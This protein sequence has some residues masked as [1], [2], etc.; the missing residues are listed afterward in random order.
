MF[1]K[2]PSLENNCVVV[3]ND[4][5]LCARRLQTY[6]LFIVN[7]LHIFFLVNNGVL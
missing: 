5:H 1:V 7:T 4:P 6:T 3:G 2:S